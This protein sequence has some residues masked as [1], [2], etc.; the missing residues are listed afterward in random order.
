MG[1]TIE[2]NEIDCNNTSSKDLKPAVGLEFSSIETADLFY[3]EY[4]RSKGFSTRKRSSYASA[5]RGGI[6]RVIFVCGCEGVYGKDSNYDDSNI[7]D[8]DEVEHEI[9]KRKKNTSTMRTDCKAMMRID[10]DVKR[11]IWYINAFVDEHNHVMVSPKKRVLMRS[12][13]YMP[14]EAKSL[15]EAFNKNRLPV[16]KVASLFG[17]SENTTFTPRDV[18][19][20][21]RTVRKSLL[22]VGDAEALHDYFRKR[23][24]E[25]PSF[26]YAIQV[27]EI[28]RAAKKFWVDARSRMAYSRFGD[29][30]TFDTTYRTNKYSMPFAPFTGT[31]HHHQSITFGF[32]LIGDE[33]KETFTWLFKTWLEAM[34]GTPPISILTDQDQAMTIAIATVLPNTRHRFCLWHIKKKFGEKLSHVF[35]K[36]SKFKRTVKAVTRFTY[37][38][39]DFENQWNSMLIEFNLTEHEW[40]KDL[41]DIREKWIPTYNRSTF[42]AGMNTTQRSESINSFFDHYVNS[43]TSLRKFV[44]SC[45]Q[46]LERMYVREREED[47]K[48]IHMKLIFASQDLLV[49]HASKVFTRVIFNK[50]HAEFNASLKYRSTIIEVNGYEHSYKVFWKVDNDIVEEFPLKINELTKSG[51]CG[52]QNFEFKGIPCRHFHHILVSRLYETEIPPHFIMERWT[53]NANKCAVLG[54]DRLEIKDDKVG[55]E[56]M[57]ISHYCRRSSELAYM[58]LGKSKKAYEMAI[59]F[60]NQ[61]FE[62]ARDIDNVE[63]EKEHGEDITI[64]QAC[65]TAVDVPDDVSNVTTA[66]KMILGDPRISQMKGRNPEKGKTNVAEDSRLQSGIELSQ[67]RKRPRTCKYCKFEGHDSRTCKQKKADQLVVVSANSGSGTA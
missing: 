67:T 41:Y 30:V 33:T 50:V 13:K 7:F 4:G 17:H 25:N 49:R 27:D 38:I 37:T 47:Y 56:A 59:D 65:T 3:K 31:N 9:G 63:L 43:R 10:L 35:F 11:K 45:D 24:I 40:L 21:L 61:A 34:G 46:S 22:D 28:G 15:A 18:Y 58:F 66:A 57:R 60:L 64:D 32:A 44:E 42:F 51:T 36:K 62:K 48:S 39:E 16:G 52:C 55:I 1:T 19:N 2:N 29:V 14:S 26:Y 5:H 53:K 12:N 8:D 6:S 54:S 23:I 20:H